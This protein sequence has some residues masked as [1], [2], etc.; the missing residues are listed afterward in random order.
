MTRLLD[1]VRFAG[2]VLL[3]LVGAG[4]ADTGVD[5]PLDDGARRSP[6]ALAEA[7]LAALAAHDEE[8]LA[9]LA[10]TRTEYESLLWPELP[11]GQH[12]TFEFVWGMSMPRTRKAR[13]DQLGEYGGLPLELLRVEVGQ[14]T[15][16]YQS[17]TL[18]K[19]SRM[20][21]KNTD[22]GVEG[23]LPLMDVLVHMAGGWKF[24]NFRDDL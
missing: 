5:S 20:W 11:D 3:L 9:A 15:E 17:F 13:R 14:E 6:E 10:V 23:Q 22:T 21:V 16:V 8:A 1:K 19:D 12:V 24:L 18:Y 4:C 2:L 7:A